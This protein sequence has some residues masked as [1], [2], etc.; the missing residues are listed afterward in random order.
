VSPGVGLAASRGVGGCGGLE[1]DV[2]GLEKKWE[3]EV[4][5]FGIV[6]GQVLDL[7][8]VYLDSLLW[9]SF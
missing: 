7:K 5:L 9:C 4:N 8:V 2:C 6:S 3:G 1:V